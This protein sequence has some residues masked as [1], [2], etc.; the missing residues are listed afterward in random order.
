MNN[1]DKIFIVAVLILFGASMISN[2][3]L[4]DR[5]IEL[6][7]LKEA[8][9]QEATISISD[10]SQTNTLASKAHE[11]GA[12]HYKLIMLQWL[13][14][15]NYGCLVNL[16]WTEID[17]IWEVKANEYQKSLDDVSNKE[18]KLEK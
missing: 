9:K 8:Y 2:A 10:V 16:N 6:E 12:A 7:K 17:S 11:L 13:M 1:K 5:N 15:N 14:E 3:I 4:W 18:T